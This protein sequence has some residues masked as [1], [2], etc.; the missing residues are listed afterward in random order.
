MILALVIA[1]GAQPAWA[2]DLGSQNQGSS[3]SANASD[4][5]G[6]VQVSAGVQSTSPSNPGSAGGSQSGTGG[7]PDPNQPY[8]CTYQVANQATLQLLG[9]G[10]PTPGQWEYPTCAGP[11]VIN[12]MPPVWVVLGQAAPPVNPAG[13][14]QQALS[15]INFPSPA[16]DMAPPATSD[17]LVDVSTWLWISPAAWQAL[18]ATA[19]AGPVSA[20]ATAAPAEVVWNM[21]DGHQV[22]CPGPGT[23]YDPSDPNA[24]TDCSY[25]WTQSSA[26]QPGGAYPVTATVYWQVAWTAVGAPGGGS[27]GLVPGP[28]AQ[29]AVR[30]AESQA[31]NTAPG[32]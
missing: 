4:S 26:A 23:P 31:V 15:Q 29:V 19:T 7:Q 10:G 11:G 21:G 20:S 1:I 12:P 6:T 27:L 14:A 28:A 2:G 32:A 16:I 17:Q 30:V 3:T 24:T 18:S 9:P 8:G 25:T 22:T 13:L 5:S